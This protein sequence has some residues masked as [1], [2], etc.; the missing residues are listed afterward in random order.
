[1]N[2]DDNDKV[3][4]LRRRPD[5]DN[6]DPWA[7]GYAAGLRATGSTF[8]SDQDA[9]P[10]VAVVR[11]LPDE[12]VELVVAR[13]AIARMTERFETL[14]SKLDPLFARLAETERRL[15]RLEHTRLS[16]VVRN[17]SASA[18][19]VSKFSGRKPCKWFSRCN[20]SRLHPAYD[21]LFLFFSAA[22]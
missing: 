19:P 17:D 4:P 8:V 6:P 7:A 21:Q 3:V 2:D 18:V 11:L 12:Y 16:I 15:E 5:P 22:W 14:V 9:A 13:E 20:L 10:V 1:M